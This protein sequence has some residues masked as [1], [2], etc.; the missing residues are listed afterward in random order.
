MIDSV[1][2]LERDRFSRTAMT[3][4]VSALLLGVMSLIAAIALPMQVLQGQQRTVPRDSAASDSA[5][6]D[7][8][9]ARLLRAEMAIELLRQ[10]L[11]VEA[12]TVVR[13]RSR[14]QLELSA[15]ILT[16]GFFTSAR[17]NTVDVPQFALPDAAAPPPAATTAGTRALGM[18]V[19][20]TRLGAALSVDSVLGGVFEGDVEMDFFGG[21]SAGPGDRRLF[22]E[23]R[24]RTARARIRWDRGSLFVGSETPLI[25]DLNPISLASVGVPGFVTAGN[26][27]N[28]IPQV[29]VSR[30]VFVFPAGIRV[31][32]QAA[33][34]APVSGV[35]FASE[36]DA[37]DAAERSARP[38]LEGRAHIR[39]GE[40]DAQSGAP[41]D[42]MLG[43][44]GGEFGVGVHRGWI[45]A[46][47]DSLSVS[48]AVS[49]DARVMVS[50]RVELRGEAYRGQLM[51]GLGGG[52]VGQSFGRAL[53]GE[54]IG[55]PL[56]NTAGW[57]QLNL[58]AHTTLIT[59]AGCGRDAVRLDDRPIRQANTSCAAH[60]LWRPA[61]PLV[62]GLEF[63]RVQTTYAERTNSANHI[64]LSFGF[65]L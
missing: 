57:M 41:S 26:L 58:Q 39:W 51:R 36:T 27:W 40:S 37:V 50:S 10:Q 62:M 56:R 60:L 1:H 13:T 64:N 9:T 20:Q 28:W 49:V 12:S 16:N 11:A 15:R 32:V 4:W 54:S 23:P 7:S 22:P 2:W 46:A 44:A 55:R 5:S 33:V 3:R 35:L 24:L 45:R 17:V 65:E 61:Q 19:R 53:V 8:L 18:S 30:D 59:G 34:M 21:V 38:Y 6:R 48:S 52:A 63:R 47:G 42:V 43:G 31:G 29:R 14:L 25:S